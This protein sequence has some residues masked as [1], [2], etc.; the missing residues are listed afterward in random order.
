MAFRL[1]LVS[2]GLLSA[3]RKFFVKYRTWRVLVPFFSSPIGPLPGWD[4]MIRGAM[5]PGN[6]RERSSFLANS[7]LTGRSQWVIATLG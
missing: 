7:R 3:L 1:A 6:V 5:I 4:R 2:L